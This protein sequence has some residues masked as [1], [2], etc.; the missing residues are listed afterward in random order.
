MQGVCGVAVDGKDSRTRRKR[1]NSREGEV[2]YGIREDT[3]AEGRTRCRVNV[4]SSVG[5]V[6]RDQTRPRRGEERKENRLVLF[7]KVGTQ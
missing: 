7:G 2:R 5:K 1:D 6:K 4:K 3:T